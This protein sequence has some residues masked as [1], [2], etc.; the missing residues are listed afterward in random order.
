MGDLVP[1]D[2]RGKYFGKRQRTIGF[3]GLLS[4]LI[5]GFLLDAFK[6]KGLVLIGFT[7][8]FII[9]FLARLIGF[10]LFKKQFVPKFR[11]KK[12]DYFSLWSFIKRHDNFGKFAISHAFFNLALMIA[13]P[14]FS[15]YMLKDL[16]LENNYILFTIISISSTLFLIFFTPLVGKFSDRYGN[17]KLF[18]I[19]C[20]LFSINP[21]LW[22]ITKNPYFLIP[23]QIVA[24]F[25]NAGFIIAVN[26]FTYDAAS[27]KK[28]ALC[29][30][31]TNMLAGLGIFIGSL[32]GGLII[33]YAHPK[34][35]STLL[36][37]FLISAIL[38]WTVTLF[39]LPQIKEERPVK[40]IPSV[41]ISFF[42]PL[43]S[44]H[45]EIHWIKRLFL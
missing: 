25:A 26:N 19:S 40:H 42:H 37:V 27:P 20:I 4:A 45:A 16:G 2:Q 39:L 21:L 32:L 35:M 6:T 8:L 41:H 29:I 7:V 44:L 18:S 31:Y 33:K 13:S 36:F 11:V 15:V 1:E 5:A 43:K 22:M 14:Y 9:A 17:R 28:R 24:G 30:T 38:R 23:I 34:F 12:K 10:M 3:V